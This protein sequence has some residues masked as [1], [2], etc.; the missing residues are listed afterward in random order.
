MV[1][2]CDKQNAIRESKTTS[3]N[4]AGSALRWKLLGGSIA[5][6]S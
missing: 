4:V 1:M 6:M 5:R 3:G 2:A